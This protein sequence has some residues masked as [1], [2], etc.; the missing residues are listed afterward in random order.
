MGKIV[1][2]VIPALNEEEGIAYTINSIPKNSLEKL[3]YK[4]ETLVVDNG[5]VDNTAN[6][7]A[8][9]GAKVIQEPK[10]GT[11]VAIKTGFKNAIG[12]VLITSDGDGTYPLNNLE[13]LLKI[14]E[15]NNLEFLTTN[16]LDG[17][18]NDSL[19]FS[20]E[21]GNKVLSKMFR[22]LF[23]INIQ[24]SQSGMMMI[25]KDILKDLVL[26]ANNFSLP[27]ELKIEACR[28]CENKWMEVPIHYYKRLGKSKIKLSV[29]FTNLVY[30]FKKRFAR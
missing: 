19:S 29:G 8:N 21:I 1:S 7:A 30:L 27:Q 14:F 11:G 20:H 23:K 6:L 28:T 24:D 5:S 18:H 3:G 17:I 16:R 25:K 9:A 2:I 10:R 13:N 15:E 12:D 22:V 26:N 4:V